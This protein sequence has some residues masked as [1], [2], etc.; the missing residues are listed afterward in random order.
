MRLN[1]ALFKQKFENFFFLT[2]S[3]LY[4]PVPSSLA[5][6]TVSSSEFPADAKVKGIDEEL[7]VKITPRWTVDLGFTWSKAQLD[8]AIPATTAISTAWS[9]PSCRQCRIS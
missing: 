7:A 4:L 8:D 3:T 5:T 1:V 2:Q 9:I 6:A